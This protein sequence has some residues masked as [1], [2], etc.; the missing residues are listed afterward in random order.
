MR[1]HSLW[2]RNKAERKAFRPTSYSASACSF[3][4]KAWAILTAVAQLR[5]PSTHISAATMGAYCRSSKSPSLVS[6]SNLGSRAALATDGK[7]LS[8]SDARRVAAIKTARIAALARKLNV[9]ASSQFLQV[10]QPAQ[11]TRLPKIWRPHRGVSMKRREILAAG[12]ALSTAPHGSARKAARGPIK[13]IAQ[14]PP[15]GLV[16]R[17]QG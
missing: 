15:G 14:F 12:A 16:D 1:L 6:T 7:V 11:P 13:I 17:S 5:Q 2:R 4:P 10:H 8:T 3:I 9:T